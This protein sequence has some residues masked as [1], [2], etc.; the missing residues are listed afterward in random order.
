MIKCKK[1]N[2]QI[3]FENVSPDYFGYCLTCDEDMYEFECIKT[4]NIKNI[5]E[6]A[7]EILFSNVNKNDIYKSNVCHTDIAE[8]MIE[9]AK[10]MCDLQKQE[11]ADQI[12]EKSYFTKDLILN[13]KNVCDE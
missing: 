8:A 11:C 5:K 4:N 13:A 10:Q 1:C 6:K 7:I 12:S 3:D 2:T 9:F